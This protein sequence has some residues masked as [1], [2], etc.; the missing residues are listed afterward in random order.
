VNVVEPGGA[1]HQFPQDQERPA[2]ADD[3]GG[4]RHRTELTISLHALILA[5]LACEDHYRVW[6]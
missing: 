4:E 3:L 5:A 6:S 1:E 2:L